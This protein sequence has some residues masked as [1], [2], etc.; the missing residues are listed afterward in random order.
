M[1]RG[2]FPSPAAT[3]VSCVAFGRNL[4][5]C[6]GVFS[7]KTCMFAGAGPPGQVGTRWES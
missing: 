1:D 3:A 6:K 5:K 4:L 2:A 7:A